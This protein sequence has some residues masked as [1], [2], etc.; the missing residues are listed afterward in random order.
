MLLCSIFWTTKGLH[1]Q[2]MD[3]GGYKLIFWRYDEKNKQTKNNII[4]TLKLCHE[5]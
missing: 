5:K 4:R 3:M 1:D 2:M